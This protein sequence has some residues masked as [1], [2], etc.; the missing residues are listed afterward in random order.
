M[1]VCVCVSNF[2]SCWS[3]SCKLNLRL[4]LQDGYIHAS[5][6]FKGARGT[7]EK[8]KYVKYNILISL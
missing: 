3:N 5:G 8:K 1:C 7:R 4:S 6:E 2:R